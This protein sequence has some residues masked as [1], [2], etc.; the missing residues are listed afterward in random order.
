MHRTGAE[1][2]AGVKTFL[3]EP[4]FP[5]AKVPTS[6]AITAGTG[7]TGGGDLTANR[8]MAV[9][10][11]TAPGTAAAGD[12][13]RIVGSVQKAA[14]LSDVANPLT[15]RGNLGL[16]G[17]AA[18]ELDSLR[19]I[20]MQHATNP[21]GDEPG[22]VVCWTAD[23]GYSSMEGYFG[24]LTAAGA[25]GTLFMTPQFVDKV[26]TDPNWG[27]YISTAQV[28]QMIAD[29]H[30]IGSHGFNH[31]SFTVYLNANGAAGLHALQMQA[32][33]DIETKFPSVKVRTG[34]YP[35]G[36]YNARVAEVVGRSHRYFR[37]IRNQ[38][39]VDAADPNGVPSTDI[40]LLSEAQI[41]A[42]VD[43]AVAARGLA[44]F[45]VHGGMDAAHHTKVA[46]VA[47]YAAAQGCRQIPFFEAMAERTA[48]KS[49]RHMVDTSGNTFH[50]TV[51][52]NRV[53]VEREDTAVA[54]FELD[55]DEV[56][57]APYIQSIGQEVPI[58]LRSRMIFGTDPLHRISV[59]RRRVFYDGATTNASTAL[60]SAAAQFR[61]DDV[62][63]TIAGIGIPG[64]TTISSVQS[65]TAVTLSAAA[66]ATA[67]GV[68]ITLGRTAPPA[69]QASGDVE[70]HG[71]VRQYATGTPTHE[72]YTGLNKTGHITPNEW[73]RT[74]AG[75]PMLIDSGTG[76]SNVDV[77]AIA[78]R[79]M[80]VS[81]GT[82]VQLQARQAPHSSLRGALQFQSAGPIWTTCTGTP[83]GVVSAPVGS[84]CT[85][86]DGGAGTTLY[87]KESGGTGN[88]GS[89][90]K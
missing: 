46:N 34:A 84:M 53:R 44:V 9:S 32:K 65:A 56:T 57:S 61:A 89:V 8:S 43:A 21:L 45:H 13:P 10:Y 47:A 20:D 72:F 75:G 30:E 82:T 83:E 40:Y 24:A 35:Y 22:P 90:A 4:V 77:R 67:T 42:L 23:D 66:T 55:M 38:V 11:G 62:G 49:N 76:A 25:R 26:G 48:F 18:G 28:N 74:G 52:A 50:P 58:E 19:R 16:G 54:A 86:E 5:T 79:L 12:D 80:R 39:V 63:L 3:S 27:A 69:F 60:T 88:T 29:G 68:T 78:L 31:E 73:L 51:R 81:D 33:A 85:R 2:I 59:G 15:A 17:A 1:T 14:N 6:R 64:G 71:I 36:Q 70:A 87:I 37:A 7:L 41:K